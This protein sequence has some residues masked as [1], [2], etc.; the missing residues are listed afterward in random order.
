MPHQL[1]E[2]RKPTDNVGRQP[3]PV[4]PHLFIYTSH[5]LWEALS[6]HVRKPL[7]SQW[8]QQMV[9]YGAWTEGQTTSTP[10][11]VGILRSKDAWVHT[12][13]STLF[14]TCPYIPI[15]TTICHCFFLHIPCKF[16]ACYIKI[17]FGCVTLEQCEKC[18]NYL[19]EFLT[20][21]IGVGSGQREKKQQK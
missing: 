19:Q 9:Q 16:P 7:T 17:Y 21:K 6:W 1:H 14:P 15:R 12:A 20:N 4:K 13:K 10:E 11:V 2:R 18:C 3:R 8:N 5:C